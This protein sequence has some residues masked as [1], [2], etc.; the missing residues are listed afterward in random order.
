MTTYVLVHGSWH[1][2]WCWNRVAPLLRSAGADVY[3]PTLTGMGERAHLAPH[4]DPKSINLDLHQQDVLQ[5]LVYQNLEDVILVGHAYAGMVIT[6]VAE[7][8]PER[9]ACLVYVNGVVPLDG[10]SMVDQIEVVR[11]GPFVDWVKDQIQRDEGFLPIPAPRP[12]VGRRW[13]ITDPDDLAWVGSLVT[14]QPAAAFAQPVRLGNPDGA[15]VPRCFI[16]SSEAGFESV[17]QRAE[18]ADWGVYHID[19]GHDPMITNPREVADIL[20]E[21]AKNH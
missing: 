7:L 4:L 2:G 14:P 21:I 6:G 12:E 5:T 3:T 19:S 11:A 1:G 18:S 9:L 17:A 20:L 15:A 8:C 10:E 13:G 16:G